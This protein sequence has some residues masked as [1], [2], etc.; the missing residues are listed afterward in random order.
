MDTEHKCT[1]L[2]DGENSQLFVKSLL[3]YVE[4][5]EED[6]TYDE[7]AHNDYRDKYL[8]GCTY[9]GF[10]P[11]ELLRSYIRFDVF[12]LRA[13][14]TRKLLEYLNSLYANTT[15]PSSVTLPKCCYQ[16]GESSK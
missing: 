11:L 8:K 16:F 1:L 3:K 13:Q 6:P 12:H 14:I 4:K 10:D 2:T 15:Q 7:N 5:E 9:F